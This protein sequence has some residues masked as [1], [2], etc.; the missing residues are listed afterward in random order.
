MNGLSGSV[1]LG[2]AKALEAMLQ[3]R[4]LEAHVVDAPPGGIGEAVHAALANRPD[5]LIV[6]AGDGTA[7]LAAGLS[8]ADGPLIA[9]LP[10]GT[11]NM[12]PHALYGQVD[13]KTALEATLAAPT[14][15][16]VSGGE[17]G[18]KPFY[19]A[20]MLGSPALWA[21]AREAVRRMRWR[22]ALMHGVRACQRAFTGRLRVRFDGLPEERVPALTLMCPLVSKVLP[23]SAGCLEA[24]ELDFH[25]ALDAARLGLRTL[26]GAWRDDSAVT[27]RRVTHGVVETR[28]RIPAILDGE[29]HRLPSRCEIVFRPVAFRALVPQATAP[30]QAHG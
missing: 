23:D 24:A 8:G 10:G 25:S 22:L 12:L 9:P 15:R 28:T 7:N 17:I 4:G 19:V 27:V 29:A 16:A 3:E 2:G 21:P 26:T 14:E 20:A 5:V 18:G 11:M 30:A 6:L 1:G 13:W